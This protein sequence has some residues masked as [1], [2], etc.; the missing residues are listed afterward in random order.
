MKSF[1]WRKILGYF[2]TGQAVN[3]TRVA[4][5]LGELATIGTSIFSVVTIFYSARIARQRFLYH[6]AKRIRHEKENSEVFIDKPGWEN[7]S[8]NRE[9][10][11]AAK[12][13]KGKG[14]DRKDDSD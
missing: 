1:S 6:R 13:R 10:E 4:F 12:L 5:E 7:P 2:L 9:R 11:S 3:L 8:Y 14:D